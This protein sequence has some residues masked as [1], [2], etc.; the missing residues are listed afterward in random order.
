MRSRAKIL[1]SQLMAIGIATEVV[2]VDNTT[3]TE[4]ELSGNFDAVIREQLSSMV[5]ARRRVH[6]L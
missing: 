5:D 1:Q 3:Y 2:A 4:L 6:I